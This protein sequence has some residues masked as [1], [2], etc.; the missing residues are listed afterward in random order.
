MMEAVAQQKKK[1][2]V[3]GFCLFLVGCSLCGSDQGERNTLC[4]LNL[5][6]ERGGSE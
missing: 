6:K 4:D 1:D 5:G 2:D 3:D